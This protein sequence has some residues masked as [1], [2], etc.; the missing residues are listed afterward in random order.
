VGGGGGRDA[1]PAP[2]VV[3]PTVPFAFLSACDS[4]TSP[5]AGCAAASAAWPGVGVSYLGVGVACLS[6]AVSCLGIGVVCLSVAVS[7]L[8]IGVSYLGIGVSCLGIGVSYLGIGVVCLSVAVSY[9]GIGVSCLG[10]GVSCLG[11][12]VSCLGVG[13]S[14]RW[15]NWRNASFD[16]SIRRSVS[17]RSSLQVVV[18]TPTSPHSTPPSNPPPPDVSGTSLRARVRKEMASGMLVA[19][20][21]VFAESGLAKSHV[22][23]IARR[24]G[25]A[26]GTLYN[27]YKD[28]DAL[29]AAVLNS[30]IEE[31][32]LEVEEAAERTRESPVR[33]ALLELAR[34]Y[35]RFVE[36]RRTFIRILSEGELTQLRHSYPTAAGIPT[37][38]WQRFREVFAKVLARA[39]ADGAL[40]SLHAELDVW[41]LMGL[42]K[43]VVMRDLRG[44]APCREA[45]ADRVID[46]FFDGVKG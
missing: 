31:L 34:T 38:C 17:R 29:L 7:Y 3:N 25:V 4:G 18:A 27:Y 21:E 37:Q 9:L 19:A 8:G 16:P 46:V 41:L 11:V 10:V 36:R 39:V 14:C 32:T 5:G 33:E 24:A 20:E 42:L 43:G 35:F 22:E 6:V 44:V 30:R 12:G 28:R 15:N 1:A 13:A 45:D 26:V 40:P 2:V 23:D